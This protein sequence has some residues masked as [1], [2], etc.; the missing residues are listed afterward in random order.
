M[1]S[2]SGG[3]KLV[4]LGLKGFE[5]FYPEKLVRG[6]VESRH[7]LL[8]RLWK[9]LIG[10][11]NCLP[12]TVVCNVFSCSSCARNRVVFSFVRNAEVLILLN[13]DNGV[14]AK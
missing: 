11:I 7:T 14:L 13:L 2:Q 5:K 10:L 6:E 4:K 1:S 3:L 9:P 8:L 12:S